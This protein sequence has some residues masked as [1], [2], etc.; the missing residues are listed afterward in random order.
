MVVGRCPITWPRHQ[1]LT[2]FALFTL[3]TKGRSGGETWNS[4]FGLAKPP[5][6][7]K[8][9]ASKTCIKVATRQTPWQPDDANDGVPLG[10][11]FLTWRL[12]RDQP[13]RLDVHVRRS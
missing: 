12:C 11:R 7:G 9:R 4:S 13:L 1:P 10:S 3:E 8:L 2:R 5:T 6:L